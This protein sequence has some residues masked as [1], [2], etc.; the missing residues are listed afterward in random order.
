MPYISVTIGQKLDAVQKEKLKTALGC[1]ITI[2]PGKTEPDLIVNIQDSGA[3]YMGGAEIPCAYI[4]LR[5]YTKTTDEAKKRFAG[6]LFAFIT[7][8]FAIPAER[9]YLTI[10]EYDNWGY[11][12][13]W[14]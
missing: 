12:G 8:E 10:G 14:H 7:R 9:Q 1:L 2:I 5:V 13:E 3:V 11:D 6:E 4:D